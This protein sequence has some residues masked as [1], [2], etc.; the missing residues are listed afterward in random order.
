MASLSARQLDQINNELKLAGYPKSKYLVVGYRLA[1]ENHLDAGV[2]AFK[3]GAE[4]GC[5][6]CMFLYIKH[7]YEGGNVCLVVTYA[8]EG[9]IRGHVPSMKYLIDCYSKSKPVNALLLVDFWIK[10]LIEF[11]DT[12]SNNINERRKEIKNDNASKCLSCGKVDSKDVTLVKCG[13]CK[14]YSYCGKTCQAFH[15]KEGHHMSECRHLILLR[16]YCKP[17]YIKEIREAIIGGEDPREIRTLQR[18]RMKLGLNRPTEDYEEL[19]FSLNNNDNDNTNNNNSTMKRGSKVKVKG[20]VKASVHNGKFGIV[21]TKLSIPAGEAAGDSSR[22]VGVKLSDES[23][24]V[25]SIKIDNLELS[26]ASATATATMT[27]N[28][29][30]PFEYLIARKDGTVHIGSTPNNI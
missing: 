29:P 17:A 23:G 22:R 16:K 28:R 15:W 12:T 3:R 30:N 7:Q 18:L 11:E 1:A 21:T 19:L 4:N 10:T 14:H 20:L 26:S 6:P 25:L 13:I 27:E 9:S 5:V 24:T 2:D 8:L